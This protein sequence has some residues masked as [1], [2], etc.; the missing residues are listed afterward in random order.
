MA[1]QFDLLKP[2]VNILIEGRMVYLRPITSL[3]INEKYLSWL[4]NPINNE[5]LEVR[6]KK[7][8]KEDIVNYINGLRKNNGCELFAIFNKKNDHVGNISIYRF[9]INNQG[10]AI[11]G[12]IIGD[13]K[14]MFLGL[15]A[16]ATILLIEY[17]FSCPEIRKIQAGIIAKN[18]KSW[19]TY[20]T[21]GFKREGVLREYSVLS[22][23]ELSDGYVYGLLK[24]EWE[25]KR[26]NLN[27]ILRNMKIVDLKEKKYGAK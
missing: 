16:E 6:H 11:F 18:E 7:Q 17:L 15:G 20:E 1:E 21:M 19:K 12:I 5:F 9:N 8:T 24:K 10:I 14:S 2:N 27:L 23:G 22:S 4:N 13:E 26:K 25:K 3:E